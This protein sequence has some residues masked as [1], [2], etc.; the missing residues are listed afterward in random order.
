MAS[1]VITPRPTRSIA[2]PVVLI[3][4]GMLFLLMTLGVLN[5][6]SLLELYGRYWPALLIL[7]G[8]I[9]LV[10]HEQSKRAGLPTRG[11]GAGGVFLALFLVLTGLSATQFIRVWPNIK[12][13]I[14]IGDNE[15]FEDFFGR[16]TFDY[17][18]E[19]SKEFPA[20]GTLRI[21]N[22]RG[23]VT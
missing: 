1:P 5:R 20:G 7:W 19:L 13:H 2:G 4:I 23:S 6:F 21:N 16:S 17:S 11:I 8:V 12:D 10:E 14:Q 9:K 15:D 22:E 18:D 3:L